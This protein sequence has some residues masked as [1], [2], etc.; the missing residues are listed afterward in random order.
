MTGKIVLGI[1][2]QALKIFA[3]RIPFIGYQQATHE[4]QSVNLHQENTRGTN[5]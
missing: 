1:Y 3:K 4:E 2:W 5:R